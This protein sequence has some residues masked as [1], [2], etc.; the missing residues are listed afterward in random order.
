MGI[1]SNLNLNLNSNPDSNSNANSNSN[2]NLKSNIN[3]SLR[4]VNNPNDIFSDLIELT[5]SSNINL[6]YYIDYLTYKKELIKNITTD[7]D[8]IINFFNEEISEILINIMI[9][10]K[11]NKINDENFKIFE[12]IYNFINL[13]DKM[14]YF[15]QDDFL[16]ILINL[17]NINILTNKINI[18]FNNFKFKDLVNINN[19]II[20]I[21]NLFYQ[22][23][24]NNIFLKTFNI[25]ITS[26]NENIIIN[27][28][29]FFAKKISIDFFMYYNSNNI[30]NKILNNTL[31]FN[32]IMNTDKKEKTNEYLNFIGILKKYKNVFVNE[33]DFYCKKHLEIY[34]NSEFELKIKFKL[35]KKQNITRLIEHLN[36][37]KNID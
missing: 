10:K 32:E 30:Y 5:Y 31:Q 15:D 19:L 22:I 29:K 26:H 4:Y 34:S 16:I 21:N 7:I 20:G 36:F 24:K 13:L 37:I 9:L 1:K 8:L 12:P 33:Y 18:F 11:K 23:H 27:E 3:N 6:I 35:K 17:F 25:I 2:S 14:N 28:L